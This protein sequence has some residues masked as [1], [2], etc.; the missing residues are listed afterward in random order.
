MHHR[1]LYRVPFAATINYSTAHL[2]YLQTHDGLS[3]QGHAVVAEFTESTFLP[4]EQ[5]PDDVAQPCAALHAPEASAS[6]G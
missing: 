3:K 5:R 4:S 6:K 1:W 2:E